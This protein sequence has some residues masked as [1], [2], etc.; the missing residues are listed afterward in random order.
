MKNTVSHDVLKLVKG[1]SANERQMLI[2]QILSMMTEGNDGGSQVHENE[3]ELL[4]QSV[5]GAVPPCPHCGTAPAGHNIIKRGHNK[6]GAQ[7]FYCKS[8]GKFFV[9]TTGSAFS[10]T[11]KPLGTW[12][13]FIELTIT[14][15]TIDI[16]VAECGLSRQTAFTWRHKILNVFQVDQEN[17]TMTGW[18][19]ADEMLIPLSY[20]GNHIKGR[21]GERRIK[22]AGVINRMP[23]DAYKRGSDNKSNSSK[24]K[25]C[26]FCMVENADQ[27]FYG[28]VP[29]V[30]FMNADTLNATLGKRVDRTSAVMLVDQYKVTRTYLKE[31]K[32]KNIVL[33]SNTSENPHE[34]KPE[35]QG[36]NRDIHLQHVNAMHTHLRKFLRDYYGV[37]S[38][39]LSHY[40]SLYIWL[41]NQDALRWKEKGLD[42]TQQRAARSG[43]YVS[44]RQIE[45][46]PMVPTHTSSLV[47]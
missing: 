11:R 44:R 20:K 31:N 18:V 4:S 9:A 45:S 23:R 43:C 5:N 19:E 36:E 40:V 32:Y 1:M 13:K 41:K 30:G 3:F 24:A 37:S 15:A 35:I 7:R 33:A 8:C 12:K 38:K 14:G 16:C 47:A 17:I 26:V 46:L 25:A 29:G 22:Q 42:I 21:I 10:R 34:H 27:T 2:D 6:N 39:Y 28:A